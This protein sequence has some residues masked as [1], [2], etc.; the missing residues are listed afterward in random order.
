MKTIEVSDEDY[1][2]LVEL[3][4]E[5]KEQPN[6]FQ[7]FPYYW[8]PISENLVLNFHGEGE[9]EKLIIDG[10]EI[11]LEETFENDESNRILFLEENNYDVDTTFE[12]LTEKQRNEFKEYLVDSCDVEIYTYDWKENIHHNPSLFL[13]D[14]KDFIKHNQHHLGRNP[15]TYAQTIW[16]MPKMEKLV[17]F[18]YKINLKE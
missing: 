10:T 8:E 18:L 2:T 5:L 3:T 1:K 9:V 15:T 13:S 16:R 14:V 11:D 17:K 4:K 6:H 12:Q 7:A